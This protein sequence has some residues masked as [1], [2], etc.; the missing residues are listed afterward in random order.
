MTLSLF[1]AGC[2][3]TPKPQ[4]IEIS[5]KPVDKPTLSLPN[6]DELN[7]RDVEWVIIT[8]ENFE[9]KAR[10]LSASG[11][12]IAFFALTDKGYEN[13]SMNLSDVRAYIQQQ[14][15]IIAAYRKYY[16]AAEL[17]MNN[18]VIKE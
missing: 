1:L 7:I 12:Q 5:S 15:A 8:E 3:L 13:L 16:E 17:T 14:K 11:G 2:S 9:E 4:T 6:A 18:A 10:V